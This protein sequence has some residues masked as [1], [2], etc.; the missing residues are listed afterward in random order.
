MSIAAM[1]GERGRL[2]GDDLAAACG[3]SLDVFFVAVSCSWFLLDVGGYKMT[4]RDVAEYAKAKLAGNMV[5][6]S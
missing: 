4:R 3:Q 5:D 1:I 6:K 2:H